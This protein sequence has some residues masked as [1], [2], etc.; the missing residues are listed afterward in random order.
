[1]EYNFKK[2]TSTNSRYENRIT[3]TSNKAFGFPTYF[4]KE[5]G[6]KDKKFA[7]LYYDEQSKAVA[8][9]FTN[10]DETGAFSITHSKQGYGGH[11]AATSFFKANK[12]DSKRYAGR[13]EWERMSA[14][15]TGLSD[16]GSLYVFKLVPKKARASVAGGENEQ[17]E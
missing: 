9:R 15:E 1:M 17:G 7:V 6:L 4:Y 12:I 13:Y 3:V 8:I 11:L 16:S 14:A 10:E 5:Q 2:F